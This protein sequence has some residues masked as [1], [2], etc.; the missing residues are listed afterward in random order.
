MQ[1]EPTTPF[2]R[3]NNGAASFGQTFAA[4]PVV[5][6]DTAKQYLANNE[7]EA[8]NPERQAA[9]RR[10]AQVENQLKYTVNQ[11]NPAYPALVE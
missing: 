6:L 5:M 4:A 11:Y 2:A 8:G 3:L 10:L 9:S 7:E 1:E